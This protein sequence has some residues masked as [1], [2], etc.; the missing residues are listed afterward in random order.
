M[1]KEKKP[2]KIAVIGCGIN[3]ISCAISLAERGHTIHIYEKKTAFSETSAKS[4]KLLHGGLRYLENGHFKLVQ[5]SLKESRNFHREDG[6]NC[7]W[8]VSELFFRYTNVFLL[9]KAW[10][11]RLLCF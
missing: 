7:M 11:H 1:P 8:N 4:S 9:P 3:G 2:L 5:E 6:E 10:L